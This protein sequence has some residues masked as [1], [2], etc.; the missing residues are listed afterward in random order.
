MGEGNFVKRGV[1][2]HSISSMYFMGIT[3]SGETWLA[4]EKAGVLDG[5]QWSI[6]FLGLKA[7]SGLG[8][9]G[10]GINF[11]LTR[12]NGNYEHLQAHAWSADVTVDIP[13]N[14][15]GYELRTLVIHEMGHFVD[16][17][18]AKA[19]DSPSN[20]ITTDDMSRVSKY[21]VNEWEWTRNDRWKYTGS[22]D[23]NT[24]PS[25][26]LWDKNSQLCIRHNCPAEDFAETFTWMTYDKT[27]ETYPSVWA[28]DRF[29][30]TYN[31]Q[32]PSEKRK[33]AVSDII[34]LLP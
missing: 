32:E 14:V 11:I 10:R 16:Y 8:L 31:Y 6:N 15:N 21:W 28:L 12:N 3:F 4:E 13:S 29:D 18:A 27:R 23:P 20:F 9:N 22:A 2:H 7:N 24:L 17:Y 5:V 33:K 25:D 30:I 19:I 26:Y 34:K 1:F